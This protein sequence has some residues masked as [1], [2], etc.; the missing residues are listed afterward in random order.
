MDAILAK[1]QFTCGRTEFSRPIPGLW[2]RP[3]V[4]RGTP[5]CQ[6]A[7]GRVPAGGGIDAKSGSGNWSESGSRLCPP[8]IIK[9]PLSTVIDI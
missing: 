4:I 2:G 5:S 3:N 1:L 7:N 9:L 8:R 6:S